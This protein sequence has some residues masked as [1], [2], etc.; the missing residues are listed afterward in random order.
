MPLAVLAALFV[1]PLIWMF[2]TSLQPREQVSKIPPE[3]W[4]RQYYVTLPGPER[5]YVTPPQPIGAPKLLVKP[6]V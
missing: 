1:G 5:V 6:L 4:P 3:L 2:A